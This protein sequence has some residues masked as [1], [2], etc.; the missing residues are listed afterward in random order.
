MLKGI[1]NNGRHTLFVIPLQKELDTTPLPADAAEFSK[2]PTSQCR[3]CGETLPQQ[4]LALHV[5]SCSK[6]AEDTEQEIDED[7]DGKQDHDDQ[8]NSHQ[9]WKGFR[10]DSISDQE[11]AFIAFY[12]ARNVEWA[13][14]TQ[15]RLEGDP[16]IGEG[17]NRYWFS[18]VMQKLKEGF[19][20]NFGRCLI[21]MLK[22]EIA[23]SQGCSMESQTTSCLHRLHS[24]L[25]DLFLMV[26][27]IIGHCFLHGGPGLTGLSPAV[28]H[29]LCGGTAETA[30]ISIRDCPDMDLREKIQIVCILQLRETSLSCASSDELKELVKF[31]VGWEAPSSTLT[32]EVINGGLPKSST[33]FETL[34]LP[35][36]LP[37]LPNIRERVD[38]VSQHK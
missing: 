17:V 24:W 13:N 1:S 30:T 4:F 34:R 28:V 32:V 8:D 29:I 22:C 37:R 16:A 18:R 10:M 6:S 12:K 21:Y 11:M 31:W 36:P 25:S 7:S 38:G 14:P 19:N 5:E 15:C 20:L 27:R 3:T 26:G 35:V 9:L 23:V 2:M 33:C